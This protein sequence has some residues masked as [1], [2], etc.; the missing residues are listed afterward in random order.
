MAK[1][2]YRV[3]HSPVEWHKVFKACA[4][5]AQK[6]MTAFLISLIQA[7]IATLAPETQNEILDHAGLLGE[8]SEASEE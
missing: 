6:P 7:H 5:L 4:A 1:S 2:N 8:G 3:I